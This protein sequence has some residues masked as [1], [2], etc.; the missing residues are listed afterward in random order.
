MVDHIKFLLDQLHHHHTV[1]DELIWPAVLRAQPDLQALFEQMEAEHARLRWVI[2]RLQTATDSWAKT[3]DESHRSAVRLAAIDL[4]TVL[5]PHLQHEEADAMPVIVAALSAQQWAPIDRKLR[6]TGA[7]P[8]MAR[9]LFWML[10]ELDDRPRGVV[11]ALLP[12]PVF[13]TMTVLFGRR[14]AR[15]SRLLWG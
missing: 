8:V 13:K 7:P 10:D 12:R 4:E 1:E 6:K 11:E 3:G 5:E 15:R 2:E 14:E 9:Q